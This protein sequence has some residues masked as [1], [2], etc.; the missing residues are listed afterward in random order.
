[1]PETEA[2]TKS[3]YLFI[4]HITAP[5]SGGFSH[6]NMTCSQQQSLWTPQWS[7]ANVR[8]SITHEAVGKTTPGN[9]PVEGANLRQDPARHMGGQPPSP[10]GVSKA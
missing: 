1:M 5:L 3:M 8:C 10:R 6:E 4:N 9:I 7:L 2:K